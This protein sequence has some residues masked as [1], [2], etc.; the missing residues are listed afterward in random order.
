MLEELKEEVCLANRRL[1][2]LELAKLTW[3]NVS[4]IDR[5][6]GM[7][8][9]KPSGIPY[10]QLRPDN[11]A[12]V[13]LEGKEVTSGL[14]PS[15]DTPTHL[16]LYRSF[17]GIG[18]VAHVHSR[19]ATAFAQALTPIPC[20]GT[21]HADVFH[22]DVPLTRMLTQ[23]ETLEQNYEENTGRVIV[24][25]FG[26][27]DPKAFP[28]VLVAGHG[29]FTW[30][31]DATQALNHAVALEEIAAIAVATR[32]INPQTP[33]LPFHLMEKHFLRKHGPRAY[34]GQRS[35]QSQG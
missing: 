8:V 25:R 35:G 24:E 13:D 5:E 9:I 32:Q 21:T 22:G 15:S 19:C 34:Y 2:T 4:G 17:Q 16:A 23:A 11:M 26:R 18:G 1:E 28:G 10:S 12:V 7:V 30:G 31:C 20:M 33:Q 27:T 29:P 3:G 6:H 14:R